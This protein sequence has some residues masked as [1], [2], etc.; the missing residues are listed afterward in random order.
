MP[1]IENIL[2][3]LCLGVL[4]VVI[5]YTILGTEGAWACTFCYCLGSA[6]ALLKSEYEQ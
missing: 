4:I 3:R 1:M 2:L 6:I 5:S